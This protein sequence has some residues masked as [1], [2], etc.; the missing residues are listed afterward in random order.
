MITTA[1]LPPL[2]WAAA[3]MMIHRTLIHW[4]DLVVLVAMFY[5]AGFGVTMGYHRLLAHRSFRAHRLVHRTLALLGALAVQGSPIPWVAHHRRHHEVGDRVGDPHSPWT[6]RRGGGAPRMWALYHAHLGW[7]LDPRL[8]YEPRRYAGDLLAD[9]FVR[10]LDAHTLPLTISSFIL[11]GL[12]AWALS[13]SAVAFL[14]GMFWG[15]AMRVFLMNHVTWGIN[16]IAHSFGRRRFATDDQSRNVALLALLTMGEGW[17]NNHH[18]F[19]ASAVHGV[20]TWELDVTGLF[21]LALEKLG[22]VRHV[23]RFPR[24]TDD[25][26]G[27]RHA[28]RRMTDRCYS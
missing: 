14:S 17:H 27:L 2:V 28:L 7:A 20:G 18:A 24:I 13:G 11:P 5:L 12:G 10:W 22:L 25:R 16:S 21:I 9:P 15:G 8:S 4:Y 26:S 19:P 6:H 3:A 1:T 23:I